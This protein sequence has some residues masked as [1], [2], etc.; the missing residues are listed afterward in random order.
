M[1]NNNQVIMI[2]RRI[3]CVSFILLI[4]CGVKKGHGVDQDKLVQHIEQQYLYLNK[5]VERTAAGDKVFPRTTSKD[6]ELVV[7]NAYDW[8]SGFYPGSLWNLYELTEDEDWK[9]EAIQ[10]TEELEQ[11][12]YWTGNHDIGFMI[13]CSYGNALKYFESP[14]YEDI[15]VQTATSLSKRFRPEAGVIQSWEA[16]D[17]W[18]SPVI[19]D[20]MMNLE[21]LFHATRISGDSTFYN[22][23]VEHADKTIKNHFRKDGS[24]FHVV[25]YDPETGEINEKVTHQGLNNESAWARGQ[26]WG[27]YGYTVT[28]RETNDSDYLD[29]AIEIAEFMRNH[30]NLPKDKIPYWDYNAP[31]REETPRDVSAASITASALYELQKYVDVEKKEVYRS[32]ADQIMQSLKSETYLAEIGTNQGFLLNHSVGSKPHKV[33]VDVP[34]NY[35]DYYFLEALLRQGEILAKFQMSLK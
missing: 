4:S 32:W 22:I 28:Y 12:Q 1:I 10:F 26:A 33:E 29:Q 27:L 3:T 23:A 24:S 8:T 16:S 13:G 5:N 30:P 21:L 6:G 19:I 34:L 15:I 25:D 11:I 35:A 31:G 18:K 20:N 9:K 14:E 17:R 7:V 2:M